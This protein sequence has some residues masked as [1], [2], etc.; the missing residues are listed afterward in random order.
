MYTMHLPC[1]VLFSVEC[2]SD[3]EWDAFLIT[4]FFKF[5]PLVV[6]AQSDRAVVDLSAIHCVRLQF[7]VLK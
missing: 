3:D 7:F 6:H 4:M 1:R 5:E 2:K